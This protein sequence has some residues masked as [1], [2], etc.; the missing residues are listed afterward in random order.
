MEAHRS[1]GALCSFEM[2]TDLKLL[3]EC[4]RYEMDNPEVQKETLV[5]IRSICQN[6]SDACDYFREIGGLLFIVSLVRCSAHLTLKEVSFYTLGVLAESSVFCQ[7]T[8]CIPELFEDVSVVLSDDRSSVSFKRIS[9]FLLLVL[10]SNNKAG[11]VFAR[12]SGCIDLLL[13]LFSRTAQSM[14]PRVESGDPRYQLWLSVCSAL[15]ACVNNPQNEE[16][17]KLCT[18]AFPRAD[19]YLQHSLQPEIVRPVCSLIG[20]SVANN[21]FSQ[22]CFVSVGGLDTLA[23]VLLQLVTNVQTG[24]MDCMLAVVVSK[25]LDACIAENRGAVHHLS[26]YS[27]VSNLIALL[28]HTSLDPEDR[29]S[30][31]LTLGHCTEDC[32]PNQYELLRGNGLP[33]MIQVLTES[34]DDETHKAATFV[35]QNC[36]H[37]TEMLSLSEQTPNAEQAAAWKIPENRHDEFWEKAKEIYRKIEYLQQQHNEDITNMEEPEESRDRSPHQRPAANAMFT[38][39]FINSH[40]KHQR[41]DPSLVGSN[42]RLLEQRNDPSLVGS[43]QRLP[44]QRN[45]PSLMGSNQRL[46]EQRNDPS[47][48]G[49]NQRLLEQR[50]D[51]SLMGSNQR[52]LEQRNDPSLV[53]SNPRLPEQRN[54]PSLVGSNPRLLEQRNDPS[55]VGSNQRLPEQRNDPSLMGSNQRLPEQRNDPSLVGSNQILPEQRNDPSLVG[56]NQILPEQRNDP[57]LMGSNQR[58]LEQRNDPSLMGSNQRLLEQRNDPSLMGSNQ[59]L[60]EQRIDPSLVGSNQILPEQR[61]D[62]SLMGSNQRLL[63]Q[64]NDPSLMGSNQRLLEQRND[65]SLMGSNQRLLEQRNDPSLMG[66]N[67]RL[68]E[69]RNYPSLVGSNQRLLEQRNDPSLVGSNQRLPEQRNDPSLVGSNQILLE[70]R[71]DPSLVGSNQRLLEQRNDPSL[72]GSNQ[73]LPEQRNDPSLVGSNQILLEQRNDPSLVGSNQRLLE[74]RND[75]SLVGSN[76]RLLEQSNKP[77]EKLQNNPSCA[78]STEQ[79]GSVPKEKTSLHVSP[80]ITAVS[81]DIAAVSPDIAALSSSGSCN[82]SDRHWAV[83]ESLTG[84]KCRDWSCRSDSSRKNPSSKHTATQTGEH[85][86]TDHSLQPYTELVQEGEETDPRRHSPNSRTSAARNSPSI[87]RPV[88]MD[89]MSLCAEIIS[90]EI[91][92]ALGSRLRCSGC[93]VTGLSMNSRNCSNILQKCPHLCDNHRIVLQKEEKYKA[94]L[95]KLLRATRIHPPHNRLSL[96]PLRPG[97]REAGQS[98]QKVHLPH[99]FLLTPIRK[100]PEE[101]ERGPKRPE[102]EERDPEEELGPAHAE[103]FPQLR[104]SDLNLEHG[105]GSPGKIQEMINNEIRSARDQ[106]PPGAATCKCRSVPCSRF[107]VES[108]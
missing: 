7:Q 13:L 30:I 93:L 87:R 89:P 9:V 34:Q 12:E 48:M 38:L 91:G 31:V 17:Q 15:S 108:Q 49:S 97:R 35:L 20:L 73:R 62:P 103:R 2:K 46:P 25:T 37:T 32:E 95:R 23:N 69:Q 78:G 98:R 27:I 81:P 96:T 77:A 4:L 44:E 53:G 90:E 82:G 16:N 106:N 50:N 80:D 51:P 45:D 105:K 26:Q 18:S 92:A 104:K 61:I 56:S 60:P 55:L 52:L 86:M 58:L 74:Q 22:D 41:K 1:G 14:L 59:R 65:P 107:H 6:N 57:S 47:L 100:R 70:Q 94:E 88:N 33:L 40:L 83:Q 19:K 5:T 21:R 8:L 28:A 43:N 76:Q 99:G 102:E 11:Q 29:F 66:S 24:G 79:E 68:L 39:P 63:E 3:L 64:R 101:E 10:V 36:R 84:P 85:H 72:V 75:P 67:Q 42:P 71:N 54:D